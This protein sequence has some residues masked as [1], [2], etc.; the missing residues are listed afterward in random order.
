MLL[1]VPPVVVGPHDAPPPVEA[2]V[3]ADEH[4]VPLYELEGLGVELDGL[5]HG[6][7]L[8]VDLGHEGG[9]GLGVV[10]AAGWGLEGGDNEVS[11]LLF[12][13]PIVPSL[14]YSPGVVPVPP[15][16]PLIPFL[17]SP[18]PLSL[19]PIIPTLHL[20]C[21]PPPP[22]PPSS[23]APTRGPGGRRSPAPYCTPLGAVHSARHTAGVGERVHSDLFMSLG[24]GG[25]ASG[26]R[27]G[28]RAVG[29]FIAY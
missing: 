2:L 7:V 25:G 16:L 21:A 20:R 22:P 4:L 8:P 28:W 5:D 6:L 14:R 13:I 1:Q 19:T 15:S 29:W 3:D 17:S 23:S 27:R 26:L 11:L 10:Q 24:C 12:V 9:H 18:L